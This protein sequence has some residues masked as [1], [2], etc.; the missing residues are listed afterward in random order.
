VRRA[1]GLRGGA[2]QADGCPNPG[3]VMVELF[4]AVVVDAA[5]MGPRR[6][7]KV[8]S[9]VVPIE[10]QRSRMHLPAVADALCIALLTSQ[11][12]FVHSLRLL[13]SS[14]SSLPAT[15]CQDL[16]EV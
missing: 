8:A 11:P 15:P 7:V 12:P 16:A 3:A 4:N 1:S 14:A 9:V 10:Q 5:V 2:Y 13:L 6:L